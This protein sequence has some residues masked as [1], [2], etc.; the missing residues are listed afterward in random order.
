[1]RVM[2]VGADFAG[3]SHSYA[4]STHTF[5]DNSTMLNVVV[6]GAGCDEMAQAPKSAATGVGRSSFASARYASG[7]LR[8]NAT[9]LSWQLI[10][11]VDATVLDELALSK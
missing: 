11:S 4:R 5:G 1:V 2:L 7:V 9:T 3:H 8:A 10:D 6:G